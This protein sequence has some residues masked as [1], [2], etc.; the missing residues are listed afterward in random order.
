VVCEAA[1]QNRDLACRDPIVA[2]SLTPHQR[3]R[4]LKLGQTEGV[5]TEK[6]KEEMKLPVQARI[7]E[8]GALF[9]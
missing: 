6:I 3:S 4:L 5:L 9:V 2:T 7:I 1:R 8:A